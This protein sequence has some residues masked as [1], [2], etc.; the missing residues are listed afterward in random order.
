MW[1]QAKTR[2]RP[3]PSISDSS[4]SLWKTS[5][6]WVLTL[7]EGCCFT[8]CVIIL[9]SKSLIPKWK[10]KK[11]VVSVHSLT[12]NTLV[13][14]TW[15]TCCWEK[16]LSAVCVSK[17]RTF[18]LLIKGYRKIVRVV[19]WTPASCTEVMFYTSSSTPYWELKPEALDMNIICFITGHKINIV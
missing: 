2:S 4:G 17:L 10:K 1:Q 11:K 13:L 14:V 7:R 5:W 19:T 16:D 15:P 8:L 9:Q 18:K 6:C 3:K 12:H